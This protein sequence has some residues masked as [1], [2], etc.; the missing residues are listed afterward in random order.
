MVLNVH[1]ENQEIINRRTAALERTPPPASDL[2]LWSLA[3]PP[4]AEAE[5][6]HRVAFL[7]EQ[8]GIRLFI[9]HVSSDLALAEVAEAKGRGQAI[10]AETC[11]HYLALDTAD[12]VGILAKINP[13]IRPRAEASQLWEGLR[14]GRLDAVGSDHGTTMRASKHAGDPWSS[15]PGFAGSGTILPTLLDAGVSRG[16]LGLGDIARLQA[17][18]ATIFQLRGKGR[19]EVGADADLVLVDLDRERTVDAELLASASDFS[20]FEGRTLRGWPQL[21]I[22]RGRVAV[23]DGRL[24][25]EPGQGRY[26]RRG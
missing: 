5:A 8:A 7:A 1:C 11:P 16:R 9:P 20:V 4:V 19:I 2:A 3:R 6:V 17:Q 22:S 13:P 26:L 15:A 21:V 23:R 10:W 14:D 24:L 18:A 12:P 25:A